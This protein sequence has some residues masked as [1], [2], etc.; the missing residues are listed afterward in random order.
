MGR[1]VSVKRASFGSICLN[2]LGRSKHFVLWC[3]VMP[4]M[5]MLV[6]G[7]AR[8]PDRQENRNPRT[9]PVCVYHK[10]ETNMGQCQGLSF[11]DQKSNTSQLTSQFPKWKR[12]KWE[13]INL[14]QSMSMP[15]TCEGLGY[16]Y[17]IFQRV[18]IKATICWLCLIRLLLMFKNSFGRNSRKE[19]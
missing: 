17:N 9:A 1:H 14:S 2:T 5:A 6:R 7:W 19:M 16:Q 13:V 8:A 18:N 12:T 4:V 3:S 11:W 10:V 15:Q